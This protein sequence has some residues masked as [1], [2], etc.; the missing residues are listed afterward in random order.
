M[1]AR[2]E[3]GVDGAS[4]RKLSAGVQWRATPHLSLGAGYRHGSANLD[5][6]F[7]FIGCCTHLVLD[8][9]AHGPALSLDLSF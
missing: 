2:A 5:V 8:Y 7:G 4:Y 1:I 3:F 6:L 9:Q